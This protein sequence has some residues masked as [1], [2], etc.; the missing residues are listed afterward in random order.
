MTEHERKRSPADLQRELQRLFQD[1]SQSNRRR[2]SEHLEKEEALKD[3]LAIARVPEILKQYIQI[4]FFRRFS[5]YLGITTLHHSQELF[6]LTHKEG[7][8]SEDTKLRMKM[9]QE[10]SR[11]HAI[12]IS[13]LAPKN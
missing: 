7:I 11:I 2:I 3:L 5:Q 6:F 1:T 4:I 9:H 8:F 12:L 10:A 13:P